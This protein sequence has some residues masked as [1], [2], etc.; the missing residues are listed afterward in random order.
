MKKILSALST[1]FLT[2]TLAFVGEVEADT[3]IQFG[4]GYRSDNINWKTSFPD[5]ILLGSES[6]LNFKDLEIFTVGGRLKSVCGDCVYYR[7]D[8]QYGWILDGTVRESDTIAA[9]ITTPISGIAEITTIHPITH[10]D[11]KGKY[12]ADFNV[13]VGYPIQQCWCPNLQII[14]TIGFSYDTQRIRAGNRDK[15]TDKLSSQQLATY[16]LV[17]G[18]RK[19]NKYRTTWWSPY[20]GLDFA[21][22]HQDCWNLYGEIEYHFGRAR[23]ERNSDTSKAF[24]DN[25]ERTRNAQGWSFKVGSL[26]F[27]R[28]NWFIDGHISYKRWTS[29]KHNDRITWKSGALGLDLGYMF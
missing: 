9:P 1:L 14:P 4:V 13:G 7:I 29:H 28:C 5:E 20:V 26:Y 21:Y 24:L 19:H 22:C 2:T 15:I 10:N 25:F 8:G 12:V 18:K 11:V 17:V 16:E 27:F 3:S 6:K 23:R